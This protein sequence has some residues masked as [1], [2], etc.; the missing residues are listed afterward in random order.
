M[1]KISKL[2]VLHGNIY[3]ENWRNQFKE[4]A[5]ETVFY[6]DNPIG[7]EEVISRLKDAD[8]T[9][10]YWT[11]INKNVFDSCPNLKY[12]GLAQT[13]FNTIDLE[14]ASEK[15]AVVTNVPIYGTDTVAEFVMGQLLACCRKTVQLDKT[16]RGGKFFDNTLRGKDLNGKTMGVI[17]YGKIGSRIGEIA[18]AF[19]MK[20]VYWDKEKLPA[21]REKGAEYRE[22]TDL[23][24]ESDFISI[25][26][27][28]NEE[29]KGLI[30]Q[31][32]LALMKP[33]AIIV[34]AARGPIIDETALIEALKEKRIGGAAL[35]VFETEPLS[36]DSPLLNLDNILLSAHHAWY[37]DGAIER[38]NTTVLENLKNYLAGNVTNKVNP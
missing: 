29:T 28:L 34:N 3:N 2:V 7:D 16:I 15:D 23:L 38:L 33:E 8:A 6:D 22:L 12:V 17:G 18:K 24:K 5:E 4:L 26:L 19:K 36:P 35:D 37:S 30:N 21:E 9:I 27:L 32:R 20:V 31:E 11:I 25:N 10:T 13:G 1:E 14:T